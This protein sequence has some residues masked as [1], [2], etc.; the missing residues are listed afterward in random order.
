M[1]TAAEFNIQYCNGVIS[2]DSPNANSWDEI[3]CNAP[4]GD[5]KTQATALCAAIKAQSHT[6]LYTVGF[7]LGTDTAA[8]TF[9]QSC[10]SDPT[11]FFR[12]DTGTDL[13]NAF[14]QIAQN[15]NSL[16]LSK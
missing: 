11:D 1:T 13:T 16:R 12:A 5:S 8:L 15:L 10:A 9:L 2:A 3:N 7:D 14:K 6:T 4:N